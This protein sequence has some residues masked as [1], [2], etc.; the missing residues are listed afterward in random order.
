MPSIDVVDVGAEKCLRMLETPKSLRKLPWQLQ[1]SGNRPYIACGW[2]LVTPSWLL[3]APLGSK[4]ARGRLV[5]IYQRG[6]SR[7]LGNHVLSNVNYGMIIFKYKDCSQQ[8]DM[9]T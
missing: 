8:E 1:H 6:F 9:Q 2:W 7:E 5:P 4:N 3:L